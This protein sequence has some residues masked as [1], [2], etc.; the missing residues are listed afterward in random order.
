VGES[1]LLADALEKPRAATVAEQ[2]GEHL[3]G[4][5]VRVPP[6]GDVPGE[7]EVAQLD[8][9]FLDDFAGGSLRRLFGQHHRRDGAGRSLRPSRL[10]LREHVGGHDVPHDEEE[11]VVRR[12]TLAVVAHDVLALKRVE[13]VAV[14]DD[15]EAI[16]AARVSGLEEPA[17]RAATG[18]VVAHVHLA[19]DDVELL[20]QLVVGQRG[21]LHDVAEHV[22]GDAR[23]GVRGI[24]VI[25][26]AVEARVGV[27]VAAD[28]L[29]LAVNLPRRT[30]GR[31]FE[32]HVFQ[33]MA[34]ARAEPAALVHTARLRPRLRGHDRRGAV[35]AQDDG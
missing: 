20:L 31:A 2:G 14:A 33:H 22:H 10:D 6:V 3:D 32:E 5:N 4:G 25:H 7:V 29:H 23:A 18:V 17:A 35:L 9:R 28:V 16:R 24:N 26:R 12:V 8:G 27:H 11:D 30:R 15:R 34:Q 19:A 1:L 13:D 21:V